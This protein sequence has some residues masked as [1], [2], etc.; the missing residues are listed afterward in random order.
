MI[1]DEFKFPSELKAGKVILAVA[2]K[3][4]YDGPVSGHEIGIEVQ[5]HR[6]VI[7]KVLKKL[8]EAKVI[9]IQGW[10]H[11]GDSNCLAPVWAWRTSS[12]QRDTKRPA[13]KTRTEINKTWNRN[14]AA[15]RSIKQRMARGT[16]TNVWT[17]LM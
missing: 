1:V 17:G 3:V 11:P 8:Y 7:H 16:P 10:V 14:H 2:K 15:Y 6:A 13:P 9:Y 4:F 5:S 12:F